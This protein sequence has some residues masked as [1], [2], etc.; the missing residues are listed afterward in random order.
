M[1]DTL[2]FGLGNPIL[3]DDR[4]G[5]WVAEK[6]SER[7]PEIDVIQAAV[8]GISILDEVQGYKKVVFIDSIIT[9]DGIPGELHKFTLDDL[10]PA[11][12]SISHHGTGLASTFATGRE[13]GYDLPEIVEIY[14]VEISNNTDFS[15]EF[16]PEVAENLPSIIERIIKESFS[17]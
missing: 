15:E 9:E 11:I 1:S 12:A 6:L 2:I 16:T 4:V 3:S 13:M 5:L 10:G 7:L 8:A 14:A 17:N